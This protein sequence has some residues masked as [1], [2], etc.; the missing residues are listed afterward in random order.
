MLYLLKMRL[1][2]KKSTNSKR[3]YNKT[4]TRLEDYVG[5]VPAHALDGDGHYQESTDSGI[6]QAMS[7]HLN[8]TCRYRSFDEYAHSIFEDYSHVNMLSFPPGSQVIFEKER[9]LF[10]PRKF[11]QYINGILTEPHMVEGH[12]I[13]RSI[14]L[15][16][17]NTYKAKAEFYPA[18]ATPHVGV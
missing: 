15:I 12:V 13:E 9:A 8:K 3:A 6:I 7:M 5:I 16:L 17:N 14:M 2:S 4:L 11:W 1:S 10:Y 18:L